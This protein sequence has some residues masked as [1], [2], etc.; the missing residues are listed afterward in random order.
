MNNFH[1]ESFFHFFQPK[2][3]K[4]ILPSCFVSLKWIQFF[5]LPVFSFVFRSQCVPLYAY[6][7]FSYLFS[8]CRTC[9]FLLK[10]HRC[11]WVGRRGTI[12]FI[13]FGEY[14][15]RTTTTKKYT[16]NPVTHENFLNYII[17][18][19]TYFNLILFV[20]WKKINL[21]YLFFMLLLFN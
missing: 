16:Q 1:L 3:K 18:V 2:N 13:C 15:K 7:P 5:L 19:I 9:F 14:T 11:V 20:S 10:F 12:Y 8:F 6:N 4:I 17:Q 21:N